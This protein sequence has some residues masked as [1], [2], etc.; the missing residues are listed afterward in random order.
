MAEYPTGSSGPVCH[1]EAVMKQW[2]ISSVGAGDA[3]EPGA[4]VSGTSVYTDGKIV[5]AECCYEQQIEHM[6][7]SAWLP[8]EAASNI[9]SS[10]RANNWLPRETTARVHRR[11]CTT[12][13]PGSSEAAH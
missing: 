5:H 7:G 3:L 2:S 13:P 11:C 10:Y 6:H 8:K 12:S 1:P 9:K 4:T